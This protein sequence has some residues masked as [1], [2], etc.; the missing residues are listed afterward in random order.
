MAPMPVEAPVISAVPWKALEEVMKFTLE[1]SGPTG[2]RRLRVIVEMTS[3][4]LNVI[5]ARF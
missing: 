5:D 2:C 3:Y 1:E 4:F